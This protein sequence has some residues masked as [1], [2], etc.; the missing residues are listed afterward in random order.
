MKKLPIGISTFSEMIN[1]NAY[2]VDKSQYV[3]KNWD[4]EKI[5]PVISI[6]FGRGLVE[7]RAELNHRA[8]RLLSEQA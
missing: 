5:H 8:L 6:S 4:W 3:Q 7:D 1:G 2:Y